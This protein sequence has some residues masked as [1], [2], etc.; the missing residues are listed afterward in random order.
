MR[1]NMLLA[2]VQG[3]SAE[4]PRNKV[5]KMMCLW[6]K[7]WTMQGNKI[8]WV[9]DGELLEWCMARYRD[10]APAVSSFDEELEALLVDEESLVVSTA[11]KSKEAVI[12][13]L[14]EQDLQRQDEFWQE[15]AKELEADA[16][17]RIANSLEA[18]A[19]EGLGLGEATGTGEG[20][21]QGQGKEEDAKEKMPETVMTHYQPSGLSP[22][23]RT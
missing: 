12:A 13:P 6:Q 18:L 7:W 10:N 17:Q 16:Q 8:M 2:Q 4:A 22:N 5:E 3:L 23:T 11:T 15:V 19:W 1:A 20:S 21:W 9:Q 14:I